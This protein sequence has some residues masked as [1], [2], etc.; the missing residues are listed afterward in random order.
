MLDLSQGVFSALRTSVGDR[1]KVVCLHNIRAEVQRL[2]VDGPGGRADMELPPHAT[3]WL[4]ND[5][6]KWIS[7]APAF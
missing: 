1:N 5:A 6:G 3:P 7:I 4:A 2:R